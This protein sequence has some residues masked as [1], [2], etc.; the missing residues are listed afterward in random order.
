MFTAGVTVTKTV[1]TAWHSS[2]ELGEAVSVYV[3][4][5][6]GLNVNPEA[7]EPLTPVE[8]DQV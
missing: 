1:A 6:V 7:A 2:P 5:V 3:P 4:E 8:G